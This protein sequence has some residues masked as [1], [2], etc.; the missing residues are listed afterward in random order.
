MIEDIDGLR[1]CPVGELNYV[2]RT[3]SVYDEAK[4]RR[5]LARQKVRRPSLI[6]LRVA[7]QAGVA[8]MAKAVG[9]AEEGVRQQQLIER[10]YELLEATDENDIDV[11]DFEA[12]AAEL[13]EREAERKRQ[14]AE[15]YPQIAAIEA[16]LE[17]HFQPYA[18]LIADKN[19]WDDVS[20]VDIVRLLLVKVGKAGEVARD[21]K[22]DDDYLV[23]Q[24]EYRAI[25]KRNRMAL[26]T[27][28]FRL[29]SI[30]ETESK[31]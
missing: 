22:R 1:S 24:G 13:A 21:L 3:P 11:P 10:W 28:A 19:Y 6:E 29:M 27:F 9:E 8:E 25:P 16:N 31:N 5:L 7:A 15:I 2:F 20:R 26:A 4:M 12:R 30:E 18:D 17:R 23:D 14:L